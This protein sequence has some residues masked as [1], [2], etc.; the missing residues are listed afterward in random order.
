MF[1]K[2][3]KFLKKKGEVLVGKEALCL[4]RNAEYTL[5][6]PIKYGDLNVSGS[7][8]I[9]EC[10][11]DLQMILETHIE[12]YLR[13]PK[14]N[15]EFF[16]CILIIPDVYVKHHVKSMLSMVLGK[17]NFKSAFLH[18]ESVM[19]TYAMAVTTACIVDIGSSKINVSCVDEGLVST[20]SIIRKHFGGD[21]INEI[22][23]RLI[24]RNKPLHHFP[25]YSLNMNYHYHRMLME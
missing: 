15:L 18:T 25:R 17:M 24:N 20:K 13:I 9:Q 14:K 4:D 19:A 5:R 16:S 3:H 23:Y 10:I 22:L 6:Y 12:T 11:E 7:Y 2:D 21:D 8:P 1:G